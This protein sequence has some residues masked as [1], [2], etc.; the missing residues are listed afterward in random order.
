MVFEGAD[1]LQC[2]LQLLGAVAFRGQGAMGDGRRGCLE[3]SGGR[4]VW[5][6]VRIARWWEDGDVVASAAWWL[7]VC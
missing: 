4:G 3:G 7:L 1:G 2:H 6:V 5:V